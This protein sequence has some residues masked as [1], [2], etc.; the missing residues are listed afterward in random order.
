MGSLIDTPMPSH[1]TSTRFTSAASAAV[2]S[3]SDAVAIVR[4]FPMQ[5]RRR[6]VE[7]RLIV[8]DHNRSAAPSIC[9][10]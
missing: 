5:L 3:I 2:F 4:S 10:Y 1:L 7:L 6:G 8:G 9:R